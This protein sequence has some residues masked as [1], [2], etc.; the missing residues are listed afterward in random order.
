MTL[1]PRAPSLQS[2]EVFVSAVDLG[3]VSKAARIHRVSQPSA[4]ARIAELERLFQ[5][6][7][8]EGTP[9]GST[10]TEPG[11]RIYQLARETLESADRLM[12][13]ARELSNQRSQQ[14]RIQ[15]SHT[16][17][18]YL[19]P[20]WLGTLRK[21]N[22]GLVP[23]LTVTNS[24]QVIRMVKASGFLGFIESHETD[25]ELE[26]AVV[27]YDELC[28]VTGKKHPWARRGRPIEPEMLAGYPLVLREKGSG[29]RSVL[30]SQMARAGF[31]QLKVEAEM[32]ST[33]AIKSTLAIRG[34]A[35]VL[36]SLAVRTEIEDG[37]LAKIDLAGLNLA[38]TLHAVWSRQKG[39]SLS[40]RELVNIAANS[41]GTAVPG[42]GSRSPA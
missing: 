38:R 10:P 11:L 22:P 13:A 16:I 30:E 4:R 40:E 12:T 15:A 35:S 36:S 9:H 7:L 3:S 32:G 1:I 34:G 21:R 27:G 29:T 39:I 2:L 25:D 6:K 5:V 17:A 26:C 31:P 33:A 24:S 18:E 37:S 23:E 28:V 42:S 41:A 20:G 19:L 8:I 14:L